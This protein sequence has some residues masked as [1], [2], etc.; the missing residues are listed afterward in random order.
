L[1]DAVVYRETVKRVF[2]EKRLNWCP[3]QAKV[4]GF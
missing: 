3:L 2:R 1:K 4:N